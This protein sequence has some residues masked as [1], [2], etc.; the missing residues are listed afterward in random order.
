MCRVSDLSSTSVCVCTHHQAAFS[1]LPQ[2]RY[3]YPECM[4]AY[5]SNLP[6]QGVPQSL[7][8]DH[9]KVNT[10]HDSC[11]I[12]II[13]SFVVV[14]CHAQNDAIHSDIMESIGKVENRQTGERQSLGDF[15]ASLAS[16]QTR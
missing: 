10:Q 15:M 11:N 2:Y 7:F 1:S 8:A 5:N 13:N 6:G 9:D 12:F 4:Q 3:Y 16:G 14:L